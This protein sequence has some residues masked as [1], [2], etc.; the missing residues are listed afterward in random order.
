[1][2]GWAPWAWIILGIALAAAEML[3]PSFFLVWP[4]VAA[5]VVG[6]LAFAWPGLGPAAQVALFAALAVAATLAGRRY[7]FTHRPERRRGPRLNQRAQRLIGHRGAARG[8]FAGGR[9][10]VE[11]DGEVWQ[12]V[13]DGDVPAGARIEVVGA[14]GMTLMIEPR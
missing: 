1:M 5:L 4:A 13:A 7:V 11:V 2:V 12:A 8:A 9:G 6:V 10:A 3:M 14:E